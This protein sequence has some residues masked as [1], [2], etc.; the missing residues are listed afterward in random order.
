VALLDSARYVSLA[1]FRKD[2]RM[3]ATPVWAAPADG[4]LYVFSAADAGKVKRLRNSPQAKVAPCTYSGELRGDWQEAEA[5][6]FDDP[7][8][9]RRALGALRRKYGPMMW[10][11]DVGARLTGRFHRRAY[12][13]VVLTRG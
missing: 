11:A 7:A 13:R 5:Y 8:E 12:I 10:L 2:G 6:L 9:I 1:T 3:V 4:N